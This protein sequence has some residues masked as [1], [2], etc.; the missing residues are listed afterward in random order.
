MDAGHIVFFAANGL[1]Q[2]GTADRIPVLLISL[3]GGAD[4][5][6]GRGHYLPGLAGI[7]NQGFFRRHPEKRR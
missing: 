7:Q 6:T 1:L 4:E 3:Q 5:E 2:P